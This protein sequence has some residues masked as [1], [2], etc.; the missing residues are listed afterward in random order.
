VTVQSGNTRGTSTDGVIF[1]SVCTTSDP[2][3]VDETDYKLQR[4]L[5]G[6][7][8]DSP[9][10]AASQYYYNTAGEFRD[11]G[12]WSYNESAA[13]YKYRRT[14][15]FLLPSAVQNSTLEIVRHN[16]SNLHVAENGTPDTTNTPDSRWE[17]VVMTYKTL[18]EDHITFIDWLESQVDMTCDIS[19]EPSLTP[20][21]ALTASGTTSAGEAVIT[22]ADNTGIDAGHVLTIDG[23]EYTVLYTIGSTK[24]VL[25]RVTTTALSDLESIAVKYDTGF[26]EYQYVP[27][28]ERRLTRW[29]ETDPSYQRG[30]V[31]RFARKLP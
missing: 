6:Y 12:A 14:F 23:N 27:Q 18:P 30:L 11:A 24:I 21:T 15:N 19:L 25:D 17:E 7:Q 3:F 20:T 8:Y 4:T 31:V 29:Y 10:V 9:M 16:R 13:V 26:G 1:S 22:V 28:P 5:D 2:L